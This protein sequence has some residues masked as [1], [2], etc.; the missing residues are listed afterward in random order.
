MK[1]ML[2]NSSYIGISFVYWP[3]VAGDLHPLGRC[4]F[5]LGAESCLPWACRCSKEAPRP[6]VDRRG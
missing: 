5:A 2:G 4:A 6:G 3:F 1:E